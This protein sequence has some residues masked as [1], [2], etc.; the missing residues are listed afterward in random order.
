VEFTDTHAKSLPYQQSVG[1]ICYWTT[2]A[3]GPHPNCS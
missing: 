3:E 1:N 2:D